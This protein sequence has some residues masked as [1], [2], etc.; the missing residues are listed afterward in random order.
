LPFKHAPYTGKSIPV[1][2]G[3]S[4]SSIRHVLGWNG[5]WLTFNWLLIV[6]IVATTIAY[7]TGLDFE[8]PHLPNLVWLAV[9]G[10]PA[11][12]AIAVG[13]VRIARTALKMFG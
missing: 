5:S 3:V 10:V 2:M 13:L 12:Y 6:P 4:L 9:T 1:E 7:E 8:H 11:L